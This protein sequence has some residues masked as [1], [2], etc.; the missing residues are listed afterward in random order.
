[1]LR[2]FTSLL[3]LGVFA[4]ELVVLLRALLRPQREPASRIAWF[5][6]ILVLP[7]VGVI[8]YLLIGEARISQRRRARFTAIDAQL[9]RPGGDPEAARELGQGPW[10]APFALA[11]T[12][13]GLPPTLGNRATLAAD[14]KAAIAGMVADIDAAQSTVH[15]CFYIWLADASGIA[16]KDALIRAAAR[17]VKVR[18]LADALGSRQFL[19]SSHWQD[20]L[21]GGVDARM[22]LPVG[23][24]VW[25]FIRGRVD[26]RNHRKLLILD[27]RI[28]WCGSQNAADPEFRIK[29]R[30][31]PWVDLMT[32][33]E[34][35]VARHCQFLFASDWMAEHG[36]DVTALFAPEPP[37]PIAAPHHITA[38]V[39]G[40]GPIL[41]YP[42][43]TGCFAELIHA[44]RRELVVTTPYFV[45]DEQ[46]LF[47]LTSAARRGVR[48]VLV[49]PRRNDSRV[50]AGASRSYYR[51]LIAAGV[52]IHEFRPG[53]LHA[54]TMIAD[55]EVG[56]IGS[57]NLDRRSFE[58]NFEN[59]VLFANP[60]FAAQIRARQDQW[61][62]QSDR[63][64]HDTVA[65]YNMFR[66]LW[67]NLLA[68]F[69]PL[70]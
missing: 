55:S 28:A 1:M 63:I 34:G 47:A 49:L 53:L 20:L 61:I 51:E 5:I 35:G 15:L 2:D 10:A 59:N 31:A 30:Y 6:T 45:P 67:Q 9:P 33:W 37:R 50:V 18:V 4:L 64:T 66:R 42:A 14:N 25:T 44:A 54:K 19:R 60:D 57:A 32:R 11:R 62:A 12:V 24:I 41:S 36:D 13:N 40:T 8:A 29:W 68:M 7:V 27:N 16:I 69:S 39:I 26:L 65:R 43:M 48:V 22:A 23:G 38:Q 17:G 56:L 46:L 21:N 70:L 3:T 52:E 58:L